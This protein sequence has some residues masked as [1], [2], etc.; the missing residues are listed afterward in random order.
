MPSNPLIR[1]ATKNRKERRPTIRKKG[2]RTNI[3]ISSAHGG[4]KPPH[5]QLAR[6]SLQPNQDGLQK[7]LFASQ[8]IKEKSHWELYNDLALVYDRE[9]IKEWD[10]SLSLM[11]VFAALFSAV[12]TAFIIASIPLLT[13]EIIPG[14]NVILEIISH[15]LNDSSTPPYTYRDLPFQPPRWWA[16]QVNALFFTSLGC[17]LMTSLISVLC[18]QWIRDFDKGLASI[19]NPADKA[20]KR[21]FRL[22][23]F[24]KWHIPTIIGVLPTL[25]V[26]ALI[27]FMAGIVIWLRGIS[28][29]VT[30]ICCVILILGGGFYVFTG[31]CAAIFPSAPFNSSAARLL[32]LLLLIVVRSFKSVYRHYFV[33]KASQD[34][35]E[36]TPSPSSKTTAFFAGHRHREDEAIN[37]DPKLPSASLLWLLSHI[38]ITNST[39]QRL[40]N[41]LAALLNVDSPESMLDSYGKYKVPWSKILAFLAG[42]IDQVELER[43]SFEPKTL[44]RLEILAQVAGVMGIQSYSETLYDLFSSPPATLPDFQS[45]P[46]GVYCRFVRWRWQIPMPGDQSSPLHFLRGLARVSNQSS[47]AFTLAWLSELQTLLVRQAKSQEFVL[48]A[49]IELCAAQTSDPLPF[50]TQDVSTALHPDV[51][52]YVIV[53]TILMLTPTISRRS[54]SRAKAQPL[55]ELL[56]TLASWYEYSKPKEDQHHHQHQK[57]ID[58]L[59]KHLVQGMLL[60][61]GYLSMEVQIRAMRQIRRPS[62][63]AL[64]QRSPEPLY[65]IEGGSES[66][67][68][69]H[70]YQYIESALQALGRGG[71]CWADE[72]SDLLFGYLRMTRKRGTRYTPRERIFSVEI[73]FTVAYLSAPDTENEKWDGSALGRFGN[74]RDPLIVILE[75]LSFLSSAMDTPSSAFLISSGIGSYI[76][77][78]LGKWLAR[79]HTDEL[80]DKVSKIRDRTLRWYAYQLLGWEYQDI[81][82]GPRDDAQWESPAWRQALF[83]W[84]IFPLRS[85]SSDN[86]VLE[87]LVQ[88][89]NRDHDLV[90]L[91][92]FSARLSEQKL[93]D[94]EYGRDRL[95][96]CKQLLLAALS[97]FPLLPHLTISSIGF[98]NR[99]LDYQDS[100]RDFINY[101]GLDWLAVLPQDTKITNSKQE[102]EETE[103]IDE[104]GPD[105]TTT[106]TTT[107]AFHVLWTWFDKGYLDSLDDQSLS[108]ILRSN[109]VST[110]AEDREPRWFLGFVVRVVNRLTSPPNVVVH[111][112]RAPVVFTEAA[113]CCIRIFDYQISQFGPGLSTTVPSDPTRSTPLPG[114]RSWFVLAYGDVFIQANF[115]A[116]QLFVRGLIRTLRGEKGL[117]YPSTPDE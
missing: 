13:E 76:L 101:G 20:L 5:D 49:L 68:T 93:E 110:Y 92:Y 2:G 113:D 69:D 77:P 28:T 43:P 39:T 18:L 46:A 9:M 22:E 42:Q 60:E 19:T 3:T 65:G 8:P 48:E 23:G 83:E 6:A 72:I 100:M 78:I 64:V 27:L 14:T 73:L 7:V 103:E 44:A 66:T 11:L 1:S 41:I 45:S 24:K 38:D 106:F 82:P 47:P 17:T 56:G 94:T 50:F 54:L 81:L 109:L 33:S 10:D 80:G 32:E 112:G 114:D 25:L 79:E 75:A 90:I 61:F 15:Q 52:R 95:P 55:D 102:I 105:S 57:E 30:A 58:L 111:S 86:T 37:L 89:A 12:L 88:R 108:T 98:M 63:Q 85:R 71:A 31:L 40:E 21:Q 97:V 4:D 29:T 87:T 91:N 96:S 59:M 117:S 36:L 26:I 104:N 34:E 35:W 107:D 70:H 99:I 51:L 74:G 115:Q 116:W 67:T 16:V 84:S 53:T 62:I